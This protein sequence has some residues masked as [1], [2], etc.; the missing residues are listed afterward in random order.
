VGQPILAAAGFQ[1]ALFASRYIDFCRKRSSHQR[2]SVTR[3]NALR[4]ISAVLKWQ[5]QIGA[6]PDP[7]A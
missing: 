2:S 1:P 3:V 5:W 4:P 7:I 6:L